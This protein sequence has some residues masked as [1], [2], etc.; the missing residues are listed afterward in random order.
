MIFL[1]H[2]LYKK[3]FNSNWVNYAAFRFR[4]M[5]RGGGGRRVCDMQGVPAS[6]EYL[7]PQFQSDNG[8]AGSGHV[9]SAAC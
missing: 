9:M 6:L 4:V 2:E 1:S 3:N 7:F 5:G 8:S